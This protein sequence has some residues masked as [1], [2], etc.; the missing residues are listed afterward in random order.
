MLRYLHVCVNKLDRT[1]FA[2]VIFNRF[3]EMATP[4]PNA[5][6][7]RICRCCFL[8]LARTAARSMRRLPDVTEISFAGEWSVCDFCRQRCTK[9]TDVWRSDAIAMCDVSTPQCLYSATS[10]CHVTLCFTSPKV[11]PKG[12]M[13]SV[14]PPDVLEFILQACSIKYANAQC[15]VRPLEANGSAAFARGLCLECSHNSG[16]RY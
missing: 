1:V 4:A 2:S 3:N 7:Q 12:H 6:S 9:V 10:T 11:K 14:K 8:E 13:L 15:P 5:P 16:C